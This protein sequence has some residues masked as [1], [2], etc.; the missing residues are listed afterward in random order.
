MATRSTI[1]IKTR[2]GKTHL[3]FCHWDGYPSNNGRILLNYYRSAKKVKE[4][5][6]MGNLSSLERYIHPKSVGRVS[7]YDSEKHIYV[8]KTTT[9]PHSGDN[10]HMDVCVFWDRDLGHDLKYCRSVSNINPYIDRDWEYRYVESERKWYFRKHD[11]MRSVNNREWVVLTEE[12]CKV[13]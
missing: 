5:I 12:D 6:S 1:E 4:L 9:E 8:K 13:K 2:S 10:K 11:I 3:I 7:K